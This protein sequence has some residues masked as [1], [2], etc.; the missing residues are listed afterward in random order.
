MSKYKIDYEKVDERAKQI[1]EQGMFS[2]ESAK[3]K[4]LNLGPKKLYK[5]GLLEGDG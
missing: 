3:E 5:M 1:A 4:I 2:E